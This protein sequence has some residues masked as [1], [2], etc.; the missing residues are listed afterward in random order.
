MTRELFWLTLTVIMTGLLWIPY[1]LDRI[2]VRGVWKTMD[3]PS[4]SDQRQSPWAERLYFAHT[5]AIE[6]LVIF[7]VL[8]L[9]LDTLGISTRTTAIACSTYFW[10][11]LAHAVA[12]AFGIPVV[13]TLAFCIGF[14]AQ[15]VLAWAI[16]SGTIAAPV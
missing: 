5:N 6:N 9:V 7:A 16:F 14:L 2:K 13:R 4:R 12:Y 10:A 8:V 15:A 1:T 11:R 3:N